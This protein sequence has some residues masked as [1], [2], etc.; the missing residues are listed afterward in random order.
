MPETLFKVPRLTA[1]EDK[2]QTAVDNI[3][4]PTLVADSGTDS[5]DT[6]QRPA[7]ALHHCRH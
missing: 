1:A 2:T 6:A 7:S 5:N 3:P 4:T